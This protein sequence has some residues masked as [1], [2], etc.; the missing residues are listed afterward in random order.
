MSK[1]W[2]P[3]A[4]HILDCITKIQR[5]QSRGNI[6]EDDIL[7]KEKYVQKLLDAAN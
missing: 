2:K 6:V 7:Y 3:Y 1:P 5:I 4:H